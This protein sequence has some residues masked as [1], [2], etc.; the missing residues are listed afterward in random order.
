MPHSL[1]P[2]GLSMEFSRSEYWSGL[3]F[4]SPGDS[5]QP[6]DRT[7]V[8]NVAGRFFISWATR[9]DLRVII[10]NKIDR[11][12]SRTKLDT[13][14]M[15]FQSKSPPYLILRDVNRHHEK[16]GHPP[17]GYGPLQTLSSFLPGRLK[18]SVFLRQGTGVP[19]IQGDRDTGI[20]PSGCRRRGWR[21]LPHFPGA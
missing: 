19:W 21:L 15:F 9:E 13:E 4:P 16:G 7:Q 12:D 17:E 5:S 2:R 10:S 18:H 8:S 6:R 20:Q 3:P 11:D 1:R 14:M